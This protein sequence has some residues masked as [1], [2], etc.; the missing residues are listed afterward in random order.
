MSRYFRAIRNSHKIYIGITT[1]IGLGL[2]VKYYSKSFYASELTKKHSNGSFR[3]VSMLPMPPNKLSK[4][5]SP[6]IY[7]ARSNNLIM[8]KDLVEKGANIDKKDHNG[9]LPLHTAIKY[10]SFDVFDFLMQQGATPSD[11]DSSDNSAF[12]I[13]VIYKRIEMLECLIKHKPHVIN[14]ANRENVT[15]LHHAISQQNIEM[16]DYLIDNGASINLNTGRWSDTPF[17]LA[18]HINNLSIVKLLIERG[19]YVNQRNYYR[20]ETPLHYAVRTNNTALVKLL[21]ENG[22]DLH[23]KNSEN[24]TPKHLALYMDY[25]PVLRYLQKLERWNVR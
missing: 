10:G 8:L 17:F 2:G 5:E 11:L 13:A 4:K 22:A 1:V 25:P 14:Y 20:N 19:A 12:H 21:V 23:I 24:K 16:I 7:A 6:M 18:I 3:S 15:P 9:D